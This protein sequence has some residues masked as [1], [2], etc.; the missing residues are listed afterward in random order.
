MCCGRG[1]ERPPRAGPAPAPLEMGGR[2]KGGGGLFRRAWDGE[3]ES[4][5]RRGRAM[6]GAGGVFQ[7]GRVRDPPRCGLLRA[8]GHF[9]YTMAN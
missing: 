3:G 8:V 9:V 2:G 6:L 5:G 4:W 1:P 7:A